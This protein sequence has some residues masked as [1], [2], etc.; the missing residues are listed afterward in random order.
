MRLA[1]ITACPRDAAEEVKK[2][3]TLILKSR[4]G[5][6]A[7]RDSQSGSWKSRESCVNAKKPSGGRRRVSNERLV[8]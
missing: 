5:E 3:C 1:G 7:V 2:S 8:L 4:G 6:G